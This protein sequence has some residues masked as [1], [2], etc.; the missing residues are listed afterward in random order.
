MA[1]FSGA[2]RRQARGPAAI[3]SA[4]DLAD[5]GGSVACRPVA[6]LVHPAGDGVLARTADSTAAD[7]LGG[8]HLS[9]GI[10]D[11]LGCSSGSGDRLP[12]LLARDLGGQFGHHLSG[13]EPAE[14]GADRNATR[15]VSALRRQAA[16][17]GPVPVAD[18]AEEQLRR[19]ASVATLRRARAQGDRSP[20]TNDD[21]AMEFFGADK[22]AAEFTPS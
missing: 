14:A 22:E 15:A 19:R 16:A 12:D 2:S 11:S 18:P 20:V 10:A 3:R 1:T 4:G 7:P 21:L 6:G 9:A 13:A 17:K 8:Q 5:A